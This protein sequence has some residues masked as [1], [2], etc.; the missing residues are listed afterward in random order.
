M[1]T[2]DA[3]P[4][5]KRVVLK[6]SGEALKGERTY[7][8]SPTIINDI[9]GEIRQ[10]H[11]RGVEIAIVIGG[12]NFFRGIEAAQ[13]DIER[14]PAD[15][16][17]MMATII[18]AIALQNSLEKKGLQVRL[19]SALDIKEVAE[20]FIPR[21]VLQHLARGRVV[22]FAAG[23]GNPF[24]TT[25]TAAA[26]R[27]IE[28]NADLLLKGTMV[29]GAFADDPKKVKNLVKFDRISYDDVIA[30]EL[31]V[32]D[33]TAVTLCKDNNLHIKIFNITQK[34]NIIKAVTDRSIGTSITS[35]AAT[36]AI[37]NGV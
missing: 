26:L 35:S 11:E 10:V 15:Y 18:N 36:A 28:I 23:T 37:S 29:D 25:D 13:L 14:I 32:M 34:G 2:G 8:I 33:I 22:I 6:L 7:G 19:V 24:F 20:P 30:Q 21:K 16:M 4:Y 27:A 1:D 17:G 3:A 12:G 5:C 9:A 31:K